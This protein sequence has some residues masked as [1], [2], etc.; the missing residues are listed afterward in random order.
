M[1]CSEQT[2]D[3]EKKPLTESSLAL[4]RARAYTDCGLPHPL[5]SVPL[6]SLP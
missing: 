3:I 1:P 6:S 2:R 4:V 5:P